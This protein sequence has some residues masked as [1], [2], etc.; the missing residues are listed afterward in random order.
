M[1]EPAANARVIAVDSL[2]RDKNTIDTYDVL[3]YLR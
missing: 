1:M 3:R 2:L